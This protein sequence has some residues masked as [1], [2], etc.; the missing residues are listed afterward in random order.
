MRRTAG[1]ALSDKLLEIPR[2]AH[3]YLRI[4][5]K[6]RNYFIGRATRF[7]E[8]NVRGDSGTPARRG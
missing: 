3:L 8:P 5:R 7:I 4:K 6:R 1:A 2:A